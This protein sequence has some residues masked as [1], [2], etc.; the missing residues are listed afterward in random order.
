FGRKKP[1][2]VG[3]V[4][5]ILGAI[6]C[7]IAWDETVFIGFRFLEALGASVATVAAITMVRDFFSQQESAKVFSLLVLIIG[8]SPLL[9]PTVGGTIIAD[10]SWQWIFVFL[11]LLAILLIMLTIFVLPVKHKPNKEVSLKIGHQ[12]RM[13]LSILKNNQFATY[14]LAGAFSFATL[15]VYVAG[16]PIIFMEVYG[17]SP[18][19]FGGIFA[20]LSVGFIG[21]SQLNILV[22]RKFTSQQIFRVALA[23]QMAVG[24]VFLLGS[25]NN[26][27]DQT[28]TLVMFFLLLLSL[29][30]TSPNAIALALEP[31]EKNLGSASALM[32]TIRIGVAGLA[33]GSIGL[34]NAVNS[35]PVTLMI[36]G[37]TLIAIIIYL[38][39]NRKRALMPG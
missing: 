35:V 9:A 11:S 2:Y 8:S 3:M 34:F 32:G 22:L 28:A 37:T 12:S 25:I 1:L 16:S 14:A 15:F 18:Q 10:L 29:G 7:I 6:G 21:G 4:I 19:A 26:W 24:M 17:V 27:Y 36:T 38:A 31:F 30:F 13:Y 33:S 23:S 39:G 20:M 5:S